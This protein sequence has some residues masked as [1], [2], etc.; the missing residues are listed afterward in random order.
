MELLHLGSLCFDGDALVTAIRL[1]DLTRFEHPTCDHFAIAFAQQIGHSADLADPLRFLGVVC[2][3][4]LRPDDQ[5]QPF[6][7]L[8]GPFNSDQL[9]AEQLEALS[10]AASQDLDP[11][12]RS[13][14]ADLVW[15]RQRKH[16]FARMAA[17][18]YLASAERLIAGEKILGEAER[19]TRAIQLARTVGRSDGFL[20]IIVERLTQIAERPSLLNCTLNSCLQALSRSPKTDPRWLYGIAV[21]RARSIPDE[22]SQ[23][24]WE[25]CFWEHAANYARQMKDDTAARDALLAAART[26]E[27]E[28]Q[29]APLQAIA[30]HFWHLAL[31]AYRNIQ[32]ADADR[33]RVHKLHLAAQSHIK[34][35]MVCIDDF[36]DD[37]SE[38]VMAAR[39]RITGKE[40]RQAIAEL[41]LA[42]HWL[43]K[44]YLRNQA[45]DA[46]R[47]YVLQHVFGTVRFGSTWKTAAIAPGGSTDAA[48]PA[49]Q[50]LHADMCQQY[51]IQ[52]PY[53]AF[54]TIEPM[55]DELVK[56]HSITLDDIAEFVAS[57]PFVPAGHESIFIVGLHAGI[58]GKFIEAI[59]VLI[60]QLEELLRC[61]LNLRHVITSSIDADGIQLEFDLNRLLLMPETESLLGEDLCFTC[62]FLFTEK[63]GYN[64]R[65]EMAHGMRSS[66]TFFS[67]EGVYAWWL[68]LHLVASQYA[69][70]LLSTGPTKGTETEMDDFA[71]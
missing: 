22:V 17:E 6:D 69:N 19:M 7:F 61:Q 38:L 30:A 18:Q 63:H 47:R 49:Q 51:R 10:L 13:L 56:L 68:V 50:R 23:I 65:N 27:R 70:A 33:E 66:A 60:P 25:R 4:R 29:L 35:E 32:G 36:S 44:N 26:Y 42:S 15:L 54:A 1:V 20:A 40:K 67:A 14:F 31:N 57:S 48:E 11:E 55:R 64:L 28:A 46:S 62:R 5:H 45:I 21:D 34:N 8:W 53:L 12:L 43:P 24:H 16:Q 2:S 58:H 52:L 3:W 37:I 71:I 59:H 41:V 9:T 39:D